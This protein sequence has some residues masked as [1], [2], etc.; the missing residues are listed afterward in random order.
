MGLVDSGS[1]S[2]G[3]PVFLR[4]L[5]PRADAPRRVARP[6]GRRVFRG[7]CHLDR[8]PVRP[9][10]RCL[11]LH[12]PQPGRRHDQRA[13]RPSGPQTPPTPASRHL[14][15]RGDAVCWD[16]CSGRLDIAACFGPNAMDH[17]QVLG[18]GSAAAFG[19]AV[20]D[21]AADQR[22]AADFRRRFPPHHRHQLAG[23][24]RP[25]P[26]AAAPD[27]ARGA[28]HLPPQPGRR[29]PVRSRRR[30]NRRQR[31]D[32]PRLFVFPRRRKTEKTRLFH[33][34][35]ARRRRKIRTTRSPRR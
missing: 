24:Q 27:A 34:K 21:R 1:H 31:P 17:L 22:A 13:A 5:R 9:A 7:L 29:R 26:Q 28:R 4:A 16:C 12:D 32:V 2:R 6:G 11:G 25:E 23:T 8:L 20:H 33:R 14:R 35:P 18:T 3:F 19:T 10:G 30:K 15:R